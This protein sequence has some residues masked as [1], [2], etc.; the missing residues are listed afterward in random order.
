VRNYDEDLPAN[1]I[2]VWVI[3]MLL[4]TLVS[5]LDSLFS[6]RAPS[7]TI[8]SIVVQLVSYPLGVG[9]SMIMPNRTFKTFGI[10]WNLNPGAFN[11]KEHGLIV[12]MANAA[13][14]GGVGYFT[15]TITAQRA[16]Y[17]QNFGWGF[18]IMLAMTTQCLGFGM[19]G[20][21]RKFLVEPAYVTHLPNS[22]IN[23]PVRS[24]IKVLKQRLT[25]LKV[26]DLAQNT[27]EY[28]FSLCSS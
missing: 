21:M 3:G 13:V 17:G 15:D 5:G 7:L 12:V 10:Q 23:S 9:W 24:Q 28:R 19:A 11:L 22:F 18:N 16:F 1:T 4:V 20:I 14:G 8:S 2:R 27:C 26:H 25:L 6:L